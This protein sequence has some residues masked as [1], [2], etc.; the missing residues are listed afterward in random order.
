[1]ILPTFIP[2]NEENDLKSG[3]FKSLGKEKPLPFKLS[4]KITDLCRYGIS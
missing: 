2:E 1:M 4:I 3:F